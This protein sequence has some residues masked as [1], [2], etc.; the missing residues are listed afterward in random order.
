MTSAPEK[1]P[2]A[3]LIALYAA[4]LG[5][6]GQFA[7]FSVPFSAL[8]AAYPSAGAE[9]GFAVSLISLLGVVF[10]LFAGILV[11]RLGFRVLLIWSLALGGVVSALQIP[12]PPLPAL[13]G[14][15]LLEGASHLVIV[16]AAPTMMAQITPSK[17]RAF[18]MTIWSTF[19]GAGFALLAWIGLPMVDAY[20]LSSV[21]L[22]HAV[23]MIASAAA[24]WHL[25]PRLGLSTGGA[26]TLRAIIQ[27]HVLAY[28]SPFTA[29]PALG[30]LCY[31][32]TYVAVL[33]V[34]PAQLSEADQRWVPGVLPLA[35]LTVSLTLGMMI[36]SRVTAVRLT[37]FG[38]LA[39]L[40]VTLLLT[41]Q[42][43]NALLLVALL[44][45]LGF[46]QAGGFAAIP[47]LNDSAEGQALANGA[48]AQMGNLGN[49]LGTP[50]LLV[51]LS[52]GGV[53]AIYVGLALCYALG[54]ALH[55]RQAARRKHEVPLL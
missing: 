18:V 45:V 24:L 42:P 12:L 31:T 54:A 30:W 6:A 50:V 51:L 17:Y 43:Q 8:Q 27:R 22:L 39:A 40:G 23:W 13:M 33:T 52:L 25:L 5:A 11:A 37:V 48:M 36:L 19:F 55:L 15:R 4:G 47:Q 34:L 32:L 35:G 41:L 49:T 38:F 26:L 14:L 20:G 10:G 21:I 46:V 44:G 7:K 1:L 3:T 2:L 28:R 29:A 16:V 9:L 53:T